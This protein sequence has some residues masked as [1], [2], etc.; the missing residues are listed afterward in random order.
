MAFKLNVLR[1]D[2]EFYQGSAVVD[3]QHF[4]QPFHVE[5]EIPGLL[6]QVG[7]VFERSLPDLISLLLLRE[8]RVIV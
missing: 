4:V 2:T 1:K 8:T 5:C 3:V 6:G 7:G